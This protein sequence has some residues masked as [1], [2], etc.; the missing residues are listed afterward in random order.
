MVIRHQEA[1]HK[2]G[3]QGNE[4]KPA[5]AQAGAGKGDACRCKETSQMTPREL[6]KL[7]MNDLAFWKKEKKG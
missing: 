3:G 7:M 2:A 4:K 5:E 1:V 6:L